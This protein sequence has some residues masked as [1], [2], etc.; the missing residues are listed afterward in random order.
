[1]KSMTCKQLGGACD[2]IFEAETFEAI[3][4]MSKKHGGDMYM[5]QDADH[6]VAIGKMQDLM[7]TPGAMEKWF[8]DKKAEFD[9]L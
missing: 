6:L 2:L 3:A 9:A 4:E 7:K 8:E 5:K 1:M